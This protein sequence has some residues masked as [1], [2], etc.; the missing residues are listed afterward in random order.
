M[1]DC[2]PASPQMC[3]N[4]EHRS[5]PQSRESFVL[6]GKDFLRPPGSVLLGTSG[7]A[8]RSRRRSLRVFCVSCG[9]VRSSGF[10]LLKRSLKAELPTFGN[11]ALRRVHS[12]FI[13]GFLDRDLVQQS[14]SL[15]F[16]SAKPKRHST[17]I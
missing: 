8:G 15:Y 10:S 5:V 3:Q 7:A 9:E 14:R 1:Q 16:L 17:L 13:W 12:A 4:G 11:A 6:A 2:V